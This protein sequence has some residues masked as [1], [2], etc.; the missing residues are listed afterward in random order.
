MLESNFEYGYDRIKNQIKEDLTESDIVL[1]P[2]HKDDH[3]TLISVVI[4]ERKIEYYDSILSTRHYSNAPKVF[5]NF[6]NSINVSIDRICISY[7]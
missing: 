4:R 3:W 5:K 1:V 6:F 2:I 7:G